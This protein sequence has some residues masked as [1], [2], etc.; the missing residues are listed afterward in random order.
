MSE[1][2]EITKDAVLAAAEQCPDAKRVLKTL[3]PDVFEEKSQPLISGGLYKNII[4]GEY[5]IH[6]NVHKLFINLKVGTFFY[7]STKYGIWKDGELT[8]LPDAKLWIDETGIIR[9]TWVS[10]HCEEMTKIR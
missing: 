6:Q 5:Y 9:D 1:K 7:S 4:N 3:F 8:Y 2:L 10:K